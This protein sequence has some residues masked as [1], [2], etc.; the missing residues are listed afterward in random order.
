M[1][2]Y[3]KQLLIYCIGLVL[4]KFCVLC[5]FLA[6]PW[7]PWIGDWALRWT[8]GNEALEITFALFIFP[9]A[10]NAI[11]YWVIDNFIMDRGAREGK[12]GAGA[13][14]SGQAYTAVAGED[15]EEEH[16]RMIMEGD[17]EG[18]EDEEDVG[19]NSRDAAK[20]K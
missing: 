4:M 9:L 3:G 15:D 2:W 11:Q 5:L 14:D 7:L 19:R 16:R 20:R 13:E 10:M 12:K 17:S 1:R 8:R 18:E 6:L